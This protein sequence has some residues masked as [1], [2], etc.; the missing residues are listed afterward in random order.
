MRFRLQRSVFEM[1]VFSL[2]CLLLVRCFAAGSRA[3]ELVDVEIRMTMSMMM[4]MMISMME[5]MVMMLIMVMM[6]MMTMMVTLILR[7]RMVVVVTYNLQVSEL[8]LWD[9]VV[10]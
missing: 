7:T 4:T 5:I 8:L 10:L 2:L 9:L 1:L 6:M 3:I